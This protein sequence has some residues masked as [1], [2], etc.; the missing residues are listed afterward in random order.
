M[1]ISRN[2]I[3]EEHV[4]HQVFVI[5]KSISNNLVFQLAILIKLAK[6]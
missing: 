3:Y 1:C 6:S 4:V 2:L 5:T